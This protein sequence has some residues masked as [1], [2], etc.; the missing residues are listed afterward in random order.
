MAETSKR[1]TGNYSI[2][3]DD[4]T[5]GNVLI[6]TDTVTINGN[7]NVVGTQTTV[8]STDT[9]ITDNTIILNDGETTNGISSGTAGIEID[10]GISA[11]GS[12]ANDRATFTFN[13]TDDVFEA[14]LGSAY[15]VLRVSEPSGSPDN[16]DVVTVSYLASLGIG[17]GGV[18]KITE[19]DSKAEI[20]DTGSTQKFTVDID[21]VEVLEVTATTLSFANVS[22]NGNSITNTATD[23]NLFL[24]TTGTGELELHSVVT[25]AE[26]ASDPSAVASKTKVYAKT[27]G[28][29]GS[30]LYTTTQNGSDE[31]VSKRKAMIFGLI[32]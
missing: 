27:P 4:G 2:V 10:R 9:A 32:F 12:T 24:S 8:S 5:S 23:E 13:E 26:Q 22:V 17:G 6:D 11:D 16:N 25:I 7:L 15:A 30:G 1:I 19:G 20:F 18:D 3:T 28:G 31:L 21:A 14:K 29:G